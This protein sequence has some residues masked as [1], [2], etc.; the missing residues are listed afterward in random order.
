MS[1]YLIYLLFKILYNL[2]FLLN[3]L[4]N[5]LGAATASPYIYVCLTN[6][7]ETNNNATKRE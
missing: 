4:E 2:Y 1:I 3:H 7:K 6:K 5:N